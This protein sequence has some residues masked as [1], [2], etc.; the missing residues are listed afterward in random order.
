MPDYAAPTRDMEFVLFDLLGADRTWQRIP[1]LAEVTRDLVGAVLE[2]GGRI[3][4]SELAPLNQAGDR[5][6]CTWKDGTV[7]T[8]PGFRDAFR[9]LAGG[10]WLLWRLIGH[11]RGDCSRGRG[12]TVNT[13]VID[14][15]G[16]GPGWRL[17]CGGRG[18][19]GD[20]AG[21]GLGDAAVVVWS[22]EGEAC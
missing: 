19:C 14:D 6:G 22:I 1:A 9:A 16:Q 3:A 10:G 4:S 5:H 11:H 8:P 17:G 7:T 13:T 2:E 12:G 18:G 15:H 21:D 20:A